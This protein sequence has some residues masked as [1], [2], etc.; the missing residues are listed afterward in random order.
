MTEPSLDARLRALLEQLGADRATRRRRTTAALADAAGVEWI[1]AYRVL[2]HLA[3]RCEVVRSGERSGAGTVVWALPGA[4]AG[5]AAP[6]KPPRRRRTAGKDWKQMHRICVCALAR[7]DER[8]FLHGP[9][10]V[11]FLVDTRDRLEVWQ[12]T[13]AV[14][15][16]QRRWLEAICARLNRDDAR[17]VRREVDQAWLDLYLAGAADV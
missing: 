6:P 17:E 4:A 12:A 14:S 15:A 8:E 7:D 3:A 1:A 9:Q 13:T 16:R 2:A 5:P 11:R 10:E